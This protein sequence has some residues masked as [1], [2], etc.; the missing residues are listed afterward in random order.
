MAAERL[1]EARAARE[2]L[3]DA[4]AS[5]SD[6][7]TNLFLDGKEV[8]A[9]LIR[10]ELRAACIAQKLVPALC[11]ASRRNLGVQPLI[12]AIVDYLP[13]PDEVPPAKAFHL[14]KE[15]EVD[16]PCDSRGQPAGPRVQ[17]AVRP[18]GRPPVL[19]AHVLG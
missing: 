6:E 1:A 4:L 3:I 18:R 5:K 11:G 10:R 12:D 9:D 2:M 13:A 14:K 19:R 15:E 8:P 17:G 16:V 7:I